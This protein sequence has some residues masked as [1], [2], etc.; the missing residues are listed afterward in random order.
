MA[1]KK[2]S[3]LDDA[4]A[5]SANDYWVVNQDHATGKALKSSLQALK[6][7]ILGGTNAGARIYFTTT[8]PDTLPDYGVDGDVTF[9]TAGKGIYQKAGGTWV[10][11]DTYATSGSSGYLRFTSTYG[12]G[13]VAIDGLSFTSSDLEGVIITSVMVESAPLIP[14][15]NDGDIP[16]FD[17]FAQDIPNDRILF[18][19]PLPPGMRVTV[20]YTAG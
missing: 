15:A 11:R 6:T 7:W 17:E 12:M 18:G 13:G 5:L 1:D 3:Q 8:A 9:D 2:V 14:V 20:M 4:A 19:A 16:A 10:L